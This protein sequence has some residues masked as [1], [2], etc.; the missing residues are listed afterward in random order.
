MANIT[1]NWSAMRLH[2]A[3][4]SR[5]APAVRC[6]V[7]AGWEPYQRQELRQP[8]RHLVTGWRGYFSILQLGKTRCRLATPASVI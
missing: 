2:G 3:P 8:E 6:V 4:V 1:I 5:P 7:G